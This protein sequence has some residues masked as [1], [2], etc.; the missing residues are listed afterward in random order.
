M[1]LLFPPRFHIWTLKA[2]PIAVQQTLLFCVK[3]IYVCFTSSSPGFEDFGTH[4][5]LPRVFMS[6]IPPCV[7]VPLFGF[8]IREGKNLSLSWAPPAV[9]DVSLISKEVV[10]H[11]MGVHYLSVKRYLKS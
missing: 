6:C 11:L 8:E 4:P 9:C 7:H 3:L 1:K 2:L 10:Q 5:A